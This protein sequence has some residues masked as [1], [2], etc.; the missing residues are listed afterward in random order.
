MSAEALEFVRSRGE[1]W[2]RAGRE[3]RWSFPVSADAKPI[4][5]ELQILGYVARKKI[6]GGGKWHFTIP[7]MQWVIAD[8]A[9]K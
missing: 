8:Q 9:S 7:G 3:P 2:V 6:N 5:N 4:I 1:E